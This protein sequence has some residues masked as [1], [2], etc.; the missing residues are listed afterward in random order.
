MEIQNPSSM[1]NRHLSITPREKRRMIL[2]VCL[3]A[4]IPKDKNYANSGLRDIVYGENV[5]VCSITRNTI[6]L[7][8]ISDS[9]TLTKI[10]VLWKYTLTNNN[11]FH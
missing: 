1:Y 6:N 7:Q 8:N 11:T 2:C 3:M 5:S 9:F 4:M 10:Y